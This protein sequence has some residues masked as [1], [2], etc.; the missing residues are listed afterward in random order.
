[1]FLFFNE[2]D[3]F[4]FHIATFNIYICIWKNIEAIQG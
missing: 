3:F 1:M 2:F 4:F